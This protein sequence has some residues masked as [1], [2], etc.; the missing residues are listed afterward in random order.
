MLA[1]YQQIRLVDRPVQADKRDALAEV[2]DGYAKEGAFGTKAGT[3]GSCMVHVPF[4]RRF[5]GTR[6]ECLKKN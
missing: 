3:A 1:T 2:L 6:A 5:G 4:E